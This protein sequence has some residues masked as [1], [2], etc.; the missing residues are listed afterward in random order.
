[1][2]TGTLPFPVMSLRLNHSFGYRNL[3]IAYFS[4][5]HVDQL[6][7][8]VT[9]LQFIQSKFPGSAITISVCVSKNAFPSLHAVCTLFVA[10]KTAVLMFEACSRLCMTN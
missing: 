8:E 9:P 3:K 10:C 6:V 5:H 7:M 2:L 4:Q 1:M